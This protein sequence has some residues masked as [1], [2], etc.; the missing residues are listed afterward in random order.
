MARWGH[1]PASSCSLLR[2]IRPC[3]SLGVLDTSY[4]FPHQTSQLVTLPGLPLSLVPRLRHGRKKERKSP[5]NTDG[6]WSL[7]VGELVQF[8]W[9][10]LLRTFK[11]IFLLVQNKIY[12]LNHLH[13]R[14]APQR[15]EHW[16]RK[17]DTEPEKHISS[18]K[19]HMEV[20]Q[21]WEL[22]K[23]KYSVFL[24]SYFCRMFRRYG[25]MQ[26]RQ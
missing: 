20:M 1:V 7:F 10:D 2:K 11:N 6:P 13:S 19:S 23:R 21:K 16:D 24:K 17:R 4:S 25:K 12:V 14:Q 9:I 18:P 8:F 26:K 22:V 5:L 3:H 15:Q